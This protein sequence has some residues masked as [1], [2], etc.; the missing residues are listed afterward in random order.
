MDADDEC[1]INRIQE[2]INFINNTINSDRLYNY[3]KSKLWISY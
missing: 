2:Q 3:T 1:D